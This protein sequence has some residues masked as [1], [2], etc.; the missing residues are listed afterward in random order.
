MASEKQK[1]RKA[2]LITGASSGIG[3]ATALALDRGGFQVI[4]GVRKKTDGEALKAEA[5]DSL[6]YLILDV[7]DVDTISNAVDEVSAIVGEDG[8]YGLMN[9]AGIIVA[10]PLELIPLEQFENQ[11]RVNVFG[12][13]AVTQ[14]FLPLLRKG[15][16]RIVIT[17]SESGKNSLPLFGPYCASKHA[18]EALADALR[19]ELRKFDIHV[20]LLEPGSVDTVLWEKTHQGLRQV[21]ENLKKDEAKLYRRDLIALEKLTNVQARM[22]IPAEKVA[23]AAVRTFQCNRPRA[24]Y[25]IGLDA[26]MI[27]LANKLTPTAIKDWGLAKLIRRYGRK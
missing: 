7:T 25:V 23:K 20:S 16:G 21:A 6:K 19:I 1:A 11:M 17:G 10:G 9:N 4:A 24:R 8:L 3:K 2:I 26:R 22:A 5:S 13:V 15:Q 18:V 14:A 27:I 12:L